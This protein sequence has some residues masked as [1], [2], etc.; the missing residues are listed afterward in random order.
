MKLEDHLQANGI[1]P[2]FK[3]R[4]AD[5][6]DIIDLTL[7]DD[8]EESEGDD[9]LRELEVCPLPLHNRLVG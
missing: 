1:M 6:E 2:L 5:P 4:K 9:E 7:D 3:K 8:V